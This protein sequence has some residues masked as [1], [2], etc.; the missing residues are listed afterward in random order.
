[1]TAAQRGAEFLDKKRPSW[2]R[3]VKL[4]DLRMYNPD[5]CVLGYTFGNFWDVLRKFQSDGDI[6]R[7][8]DDTAWAA[9]HGF[10]VPVGRSG[11]YERLGL[12]WAELIRERRAAKRKKA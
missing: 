12:A 6:S 1:M 8:T 3:K 9:R 2:Y 4:T 11:S 5:M 7:R 10:N